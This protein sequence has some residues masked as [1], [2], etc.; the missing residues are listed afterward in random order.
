MIAI[1]DEEGDLPAL[2]RCFRRRAPIAL[3]LVLAAWARADERD[4]PA[5]A[6]PPPRLRPG[7]AATYRDE[8]GSATAIVI[9]PHF[10]L[11]AGE[12]LHPAIDAAFSAE[13][14]GVIA[15]LE[16]GEYR[17]TARVEGGAA[18]VSAA[19]RLADAAPLR[20]PAG[21]HEISIA[22]VRLDGRSPARLELR[23]ESERFADE[24]VPSSALFHEAAS[25]SMDDAGEVE[26]GRVLI[27]ELG[28]LHCHAASSPSLKARRG[29]RLHGSGSRLRHSWLERWLAD[30]RSCRAD[31]VMP[32]LVDR[33]EA[34]DIADHLASLRDA[35]A[36]AVDLEPDFSEHGRFKG[37]EL[38]ET[39]G[40]AACHA[41]PRRE[42]AGL[43]AKFAPRGLV[44]YLLD[45]EAVHPD[46][47]MPGMLLGRDEARELAAW[48]LD[49]ESAGAAPEPR[50]YAGAARGRRLL[51]E[52]ACRRCHDH[53]DSGAERSAAA[54]PLE[55]LPA[56]GGCLEAEPRRPLPRYALDEPSRRAIA[57]YLTRLRSQ[58]ER[59]PAPL[60]EAERRIRALRCAACHAWDGSAP[61]PALGERAPPLAGAGAKL[62][63]AWIDEVLLGK[64]RV[65]GDL[66]LR[67]PR[68]PA[69][70][71]AGLSRALAAFAG[72]GEEPDGEA[73]AAA[74]PGAALDR[75]RERGLALLGRDA[76]RGGLACVACHD[77]KEH[78]AVA[79]ER[80]PQLADTAE[81][82]RFDWFR[83]WMLDPGRIASGTAMPQFFAGERAAEAPDAIAALWAA[84]SL[85]A[86][87]PEPPGLRDFDA[88]LADE[89][90]PLPLSGA[91]VQRFILPEASAAAFAIG[92]PKEGKL[93]PVSACFDAAVCRLAYAWEGGFIDLSRSLGKLQERAAL[94]G[95]VFYRRREFPFR[96]GDRDRAPSPRFL[97]YRLA[98]GYP[99][100][101]YEAG[102]ARIA[103]RV[104][105]LRTASGLVEEFRV[106]GA[107][108]TVWFLIEDAPGVAIGATAGV[109][110]DGALRFAPA[111]SLRFDLRLER[112]EAR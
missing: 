73:P 38:F 31:A 42:L 99:E 100:F 32:S 63:A 20:L 111:A 56:S 33:A 34:S 60:H 82:L 74:A 71:L 67:M 69:R 80:G 105:P 98:G 76:E 77:F 23:W 102:G 95:E 6:E 11:A 30:P 64:R 14:R 9:A 112:K 68:F 83:R 43:A 48:L 85:G 29:P 3:A 66:R 39:I 87:M 41:A 93:P 40:C 15:I 84:L 72:R 79:D 46:G 109:L 59:S 21:H 97:G 5:P 101:T 35:A 18:A 78:R 36:E 49:G 51:A 37:R 47:R 1:L 4:V 108:G 8:R 7:L 86:A 26:R 89:V 25:V 96:I 107:A 50:T 17:F 110:E 65:R 75:L 61:A 12:S 27:E 55:A 81:R 2:P 103:E 13:W 88:A 70:Q 24:P 22:F 62:R 94:A 52:R 92:L 58:P 53:P 10:A 90:R 91:I 104:L 106:E 28:C 44:A 16:G 54:T 57:A 19:G 45:P